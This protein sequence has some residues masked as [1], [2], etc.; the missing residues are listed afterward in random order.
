MN[1]YG[2]LSTDR[3]KIIE[4]RRAD[5]KKWLTL[6]GTDTPIIHPTHDDYMT[7]GWF[8]YVVPVV[9]HTTQRQGDILISET[10][11]TYLVTN[12]T[13]EELRSSMIVTPWQIRKAL[14]QTG[15]RVAVTSA[16]SQADQDTQDGWEHASQFERLNPLVVSLGADLGMTDIEL[17]DLFILAATL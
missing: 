16:M 2:L 4:T 6:P 1:T 11:Y 14:N 7:A 15:K 3:L 17:D 13:P 5:S 10:T 8:L 12:K 9:D